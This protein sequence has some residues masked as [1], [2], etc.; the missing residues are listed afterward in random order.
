MLLRLT[1][2]ESQ[3][4]PIWSIRSGNRR[5]AKAPV[6]SRVR[7]GNHGQRTPVEMTRSKKQANL[8]QTTINP[9]AILSRAVIG[10][11]L[12]L[13]FKVL[14]FAL[15]IGC[16]AILA[17]LLTPN[18]FGLVAMAMPVI[19]FLQMF[20]QLG[21]RTAT[22]QQEKIE[23]PDVSTMFWAGIAAS[24]I[25]GL[26]TVLA[27]P[28]IAAAYGEPEVEPILSV[29]A[30]MFV[31]TALGAQHGALL[32][33]QMQFGTVVAIGFSSQLIASIVSVYLALN[34]AGYWALIC[35]QLGWSLVATTLYWI[36]V[37]WVPR[38]T[39][40]SKSAKSMLLFSGHLTGFNIINFFGRQ[41]DNMLLGFMYGAAEL[42]PY[43]L[44]YRLLRLP[45]DS[46]NQPLQTVLLPALSRLQSDPRRYEDLYA[47]VLSVSTMLTM[48]PIVF[49]AVM[50]E[51]LIVFV[52][53]EQW[54]Q[55]ADIFVFLAIAS[56]F[57]V[58]YTTIGLLLLSSGKPKRLMQ[59]GLIGNPIIV[60]FF[61]A[62]LPWGAEG[63]AAAYA[64]ITALLVIPG[65][66]FALRTVPVHYNTILAAI[67]PAAATAALVGAAVYAFK[68]AYP[69]FAA[70]NLGLLT[71][72]VIAFCTYIGSTLIVW[73]PRTIAARVAQISAL[74]RS[75]EDI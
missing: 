26:L 5:L 63:V 8:F 54:R 15:Q 16:V 31:V 65:F 70:T 11:S 62:G 69:I 27:A 28:L 32:E 22:I 29:L 59:W 18:D 14:S 49:A 24:C 37:G 71:A 56:F 42:G 74:R 10:G 44:A 73:G 61:V 2:N 7:T 3:G 1:L 57:Q 38:R 23:A 68:I 12:L 52:V 35:L 72:I 64:I 41:S 40:W 46:I 48:P 9:S 67:R 43:S 19:V 30:A 51:P 4:T 47:S 50:A 39:S 58:F 75:R 60:L 33:R 6:P 45:L 13:P 53:G 36:S 66:A 17:R 34:G 25:C 20:A 21:T 55:T